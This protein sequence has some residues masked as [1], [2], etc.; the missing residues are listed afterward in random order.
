MHVQV[1]VAAQ[2]RRD[3]IAQL[4]AQYEEMLI[5]LK[6][7]GALLNTVSPEGLLS[8]EDYVVFKV[9]PRIVSRPVIGQGED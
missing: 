6:E 5:F 1:R 3:R 2:G 4:M 7:K 8:R 9:W